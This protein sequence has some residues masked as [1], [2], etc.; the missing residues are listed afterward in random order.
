MADIV[1]DI[2]RVTVAA[3][4][5]SELQVEMINLNYRCVTSGGADTRAGLAAAV[6]AG[7]IG[8]YDN[9]MSFNSSIYGWKVAYINRTPPPSPLTGGTS[10]PGAVATFFLPTQ[11]RPLLRWLTG[12]T[13]RGYRGRVFMFSPAASKVTTGGIPSTDVTT[14]MATFGT[15]ATAPIVTG[16]STWHLVIAHRSLPPV[17]TWT[18]TDV[19]GYTAIQKYAT[20][21]RS[22]QY[23]RPN[24]IPPW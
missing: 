19:T 23:G 20:Q 3:T 16:G 24:V 5:T 1:G 12:F 9:I 11:N 21:R 22:G 17:V 7:L 2:V 18:T 6:Y 8:S 14:A 15:A 13:G 10:S 4:Y